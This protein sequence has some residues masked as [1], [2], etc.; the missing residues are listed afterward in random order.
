MPSKASVPGMLTSSL[1]DASVYFTIITMHQVTGQG[2]VQ[3]GPSLAGR[4]GRR[5]C[6][7]AWTKKML[8]FL[9]KIAH[10]IEQFLSN[11]D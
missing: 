3:R 1:A 8:K 9:V 5:Q 11:T 10:S 2:H 6:T 4:I 7:Y